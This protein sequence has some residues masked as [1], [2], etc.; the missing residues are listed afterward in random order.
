MSPTENEYV[1]TIKW[2][3]V[4]DC[5]TYQPSLQKNLRFITQYTGN[6]VNVVFDREPWKH[7]SVLFAKREIFFGRY[8]LLHQPTVKY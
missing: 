5:V 7:L 3:G 2:N 1:I 8:M 6:D 4:A